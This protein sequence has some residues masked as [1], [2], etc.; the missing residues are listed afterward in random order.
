MEIELVVVTQFKN[1]YLHRRN[2][3]LIMAFEDGES[4][5]RN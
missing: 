3:V 5:L 2:E 1:L 4:S